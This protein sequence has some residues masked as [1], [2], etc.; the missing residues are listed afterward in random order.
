MSG[1]PATTG[2]WSKGPPRP[3]VAAEPIDCSEL[4]MQ[5]LRGA[6]L[7]MSGQTQRLVEI[8][9]IELMKVIESFRNELDTRVVE[10]NSLTK[11]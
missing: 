7:V 4:T 11:V 8:A 9:E 1:V 3:R 6:Q 10:E 2:F 5:E